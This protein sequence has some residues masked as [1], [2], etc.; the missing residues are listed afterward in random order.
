VIGVKMLI[1]HTVLILNIFLKELGL[2]I[3]V[4]LILIKSSKKKLS[5]KR[6]QTKVIAVQG[7][8]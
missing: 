4:R 8:S 1:I 2:A 3:D 6:W 5:K 7:A